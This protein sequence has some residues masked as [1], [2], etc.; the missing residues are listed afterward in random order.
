M[1]YK[2]SE[3]GNK[4]RHQNKLLLSNVKRTDAMD[5]ENRVLYFLFCK[6]TTV[7]PKISFFWNPCHIGTT[8]WF[9]MQMGYLVSVSNDFLVRTIVK[10]TFCFCL[11]YVKKTCKVDSMPDECSGRKLRL[12]YLW[13]FDFSFPLL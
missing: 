3:L 7:C 6:C 2:K 9:A 13:K 5:W 12:G 1:L 10:E 8:N 4:C 11:F